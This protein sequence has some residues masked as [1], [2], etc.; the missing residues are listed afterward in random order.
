MLAAV[1]AA[2]L[3]LLPAQ[4]LYVVA[5]GFIGGAFLKLAPHLVALKSKWRLFRPTVDLK[6][7]VV[8]KMIALGL[9]LLGGIIISEG[10]GIYLQR[11]ADD[12]H[13]QIA[14]SRAALKWSRIIG[15]TLIQIFPYALSIGIFPYLADQARSR[16]KQPLTDTLVGA[17][18]VCVFV[19]GPITA[20]LIAVR[21]PLLSAVWQSG[22]LT[23]HDTVV[24]SYPFVGFTIGLIG[25]ACE[26]MLNQTFYAMTNVWIPTAIGILTSGL[27]I[28]IAVVGIHKGYGLAAIA[29]AESISKSIKCFILWGMLRPRLGKVH[30][31]ENLRF[32]LQVLAGAALAGAASGLVASVI[33]PAS[34][35][36]GHLKLKM[37]LAVS[38]AGLVGVGVYWLFCSLF[39]LSEMN[40]IRKA[41]PDIRRQSARVYQM[42]GRALMAPW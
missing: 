26:M 6:D 19:F 4:A 30:V 23:Q 7:P 24:M 40:H 3:G 15:D 32:L 35:H 34:A 11:L 25:F 10:R 13:I 12:P 18:R 16:D 8:R 17:L 42:F 41:L 39:D 38:V 37:L 5:F 31:A 33:A 20:I 1:A 21:F 2:A 14:A 28:V 27:W 9:P 36:G 29:A 22:R